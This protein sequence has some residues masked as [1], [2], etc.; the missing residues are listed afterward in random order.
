VIWEQLQHH[1]SPEAICAHLRATFPDAPASLE[2]D[3][4]GFL[5]DLLTHELIVA[6]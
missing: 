4:A 6:G 5:A 1:Q 3:V 2:Q